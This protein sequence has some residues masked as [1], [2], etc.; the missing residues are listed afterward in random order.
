MRD[1]LAGARRRRRA[2]ADVPCDRSRA[3][4]PLRARD[5]A[6]LA[7]KAILLA[8]IVRSLHRAYRFRPLAEFANRDRVGE[9]PPAAAGALSRRPRRPPAT[10]SARPDAPRSTATTRSASA[11]GTGSTSRTCWSSSFVS[12]SPR[13]RRSE[14]LPARRAARSPSTSTRTSTSSSRRCSTSGSASATTSASSA[15]TTRRSTR[16]PAR[17]PAYLLTMPTRFPRSSVVRLEENYRST[18][19]S[20]SSRTGLVPRLGGAEKTLRAVR[21]PGSGARASAPFASI[22]E[23]V[24]ELVGRICRLREDGVARTRSPCSTA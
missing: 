17:R 12:T 4:P 21:P 13:R 2:G 18:P 7:S 24:A 8:P 10:G 15:T 14:Q 23:E 19:R 1:R 16:S 3:A 6:I 22:D 20:W 11:A 5:R 9:E